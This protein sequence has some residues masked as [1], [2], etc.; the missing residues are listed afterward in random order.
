MPI[1]PGSCSVPSPGWQL[2]VLDENGNK[3]TKPGEVGALAGKLPL[4]PGTFPTLWNADQRFKD[5]YLTEY[6]GYY[7]TGDAGFIDAR[8][9]TSR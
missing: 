3:I 1:K 9:A 4:P 8:T 5:A 2:D 7:K 6:P